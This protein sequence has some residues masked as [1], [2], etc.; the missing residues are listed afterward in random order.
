MALPR[1]ELSILLRDLRAAGPVDRVRLLAR[2]LSSLRRLSPWDRK[3]LL[4]MAGFEGA[5]ALVERLA[6][7]DEATAGRLRRLLAEL[8]KEP[9]EL[10]RTVRELGDP[11]RRSAAVDELLATLDRGMTAEEEAE[12][13]AALPNLPPG[14]VPEPPP[15]PPAGAGAAPLPEAPPVPERPVPLTRPAA[16]HGTRPSVGR[17]SGPAAGGTPALPT[18]A[19]APVPKPSRAEQV[20]GPPPSEEPPPPEI[21]AEAHE[22]QARLQEAEPEARPEPLPKPPPPS[23]APVPAAPPEPADGAPASATQ[24]LDRL[25]ALRRGAAGPPPDAR[26]LGRTLDR[27]LPFPW[28]RR[29]ALQ[30]WIEAGGAADLDGALDL[31]GELPAAADRTW[32]LA[33][34]M[35]HGAWSDGE[36]KRIAG[37][38][39]TPAAR[40]RLERRLRA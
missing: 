26:E 28:A 29:R 16:P 7:D 4:R 12:P 32:C 21:P 13:E 25:L 36:R 6:Q 11:K 9:A 31:I 5:E 38:A 15:V 22:L 3:I 10:E 33:T 17:A 27:D 14:P 8:E 30:A 40:R 20:S 34:L 35:A 24:V 19:E 37:A 1:G 18:S 23:S 39:P 2:S